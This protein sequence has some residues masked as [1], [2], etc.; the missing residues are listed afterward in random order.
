M[1]Y[2]AGDEHAATE[3]KLFVDNDADLYRQRTT[4]IYRN[5][6]TKMRKGVYD[7]VASSLA[8]HFEVE[9]RLGNYD[10]LL[11]KKYQKK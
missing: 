8:A 7:H 6:V 1:A 2:Q 9:A 4:P 11:P 5:L 10:S 3:L